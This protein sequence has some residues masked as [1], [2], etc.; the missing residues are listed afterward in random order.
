MFYI[1]VLARSLK[2]H[3]NRDREK[4]IITKIEI[5][6]YLKE[7]KR[8]VLELEII[9][10]SSSATGKLLFESDLN[11]HRAY[12]CICVGAWT[13]ISTDLPVAL[14]EGQTKK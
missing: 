7:Q 5:Y 10:S 2:Y 8:T 1:S 6:K 13:V 3:Y 9:R 14:L 4:V 11:E 12:T